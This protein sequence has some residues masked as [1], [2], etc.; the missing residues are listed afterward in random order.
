MLQLK[1]AKH[2]YQ[3][4]F[5]K[6]LLYFYYYIGSL[7][8]S[9]RTYIT[10][11]VYLLP[12]LFFFYYSSFYMRCFCWFFVSERIEF[13]L[14]SNWGVTSINKTYFIRRL[15]IGRVGIQVFIAIERDNGFIKVYFPII[16]FILLPEKKTE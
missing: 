7:I 6:F 15:R 2:V 9:I 13:R 8:R 14:A 10:Y 5:A 11:T 3:S 4:N 16:N 1:L 12:S